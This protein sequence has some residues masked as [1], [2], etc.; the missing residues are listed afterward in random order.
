MI[1]QILKVVLIPILGILTKYIIDFLTA[2][3]NELEN[4]IENET[5]DKYLKMITDTVVNCVIATNQTYV[6]SL[7][8]QNAFTEEAQKEAF[9]RTMNAV[10]AILSQDAK[11]YIVEMTGDLKTYLTQLIEVN[12]NNKKGTLN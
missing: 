5:A 1:T 12:V 9:N 4:K 7:K 11:D 3:S 6:D 2:K 10:L 8:K